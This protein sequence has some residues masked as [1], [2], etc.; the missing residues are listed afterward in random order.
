MVTK[1]ARKFSGGRQPGRGDAAQVELVF[2][3][4]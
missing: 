1:S 3:R 4:R 2:A